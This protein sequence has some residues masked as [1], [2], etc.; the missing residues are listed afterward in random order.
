MTLVTVICFGLVV[1]AQGVVWRGTHKVCG[2]GA[3]LTLYQTGRMVFWHNNRKEE[4]R[5]NIHDGYLNLF[6]ENGRKLYSFKYSYT[7]STNTLNWVDAGRVRMSRC[8]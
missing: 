6:D 4:G 3:E 2:D 5:Y 8:R 1:E 7:S